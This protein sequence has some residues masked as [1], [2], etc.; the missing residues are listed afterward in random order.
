MPAM[1]RQDSNPHIANIAIALSGA[2]L[3]GVFTLMF[4]PLAPH[5]AG[6]SHAFASDFFSIAT[7]MAIA[8][9]VAR[10]LV[11]K[12]RSDHQ[13]QMERDLLEAF[14]EHIPDNVFFKDRESKFIRISRAMADYIG[15]AEPSQAIDKSDS[16]IFSSE[17]AGIAYADEQEIMRTGRPLVGIEEKETWPDGRESWALTTKVPLLNRTGQIIGTMGIARNIT[18]RKHA[19][20]RLRHMALHD[21]LTGLPNRALLEDG[22]GRAIAMAH[23]NHKC[24]AVLMLDLDRFKNIND[25][26][27]HHAGDLVLQAVAS[28]LKNGLRE[29]DI[30][31]R[32]GGDEFVIVLPSANG[33]EDVE[34]VAQKVI[35]RMVEPFQIDGTNLRVGVSIGICEYPADGEN[36]ESLLQCADAALYEVKKEG[37]GLYRFFT[38]D[39]IVA[40]VHRQNLENDL[41]Q[42]WEQ[43]Q[44]VLHYQP[45]VST[46]A[47]RMIGVEALMRWH[48]PE[49]GLIPPNR[50]IPQLEELGLMV[51][52]GA[53]ALATACRQNAAWQQEGLPPIRVAVN[54]S[55]QQFYRGDIVGVV[56]KTLRETGLDPKW[57]EL[58]LTESLTLDDSETTIKIMQELKRLGVSLSLDDFGTGWSSLSYLRRFPLD[59]LKIDRSFVREIGTEPASEAIVRGIITLGQNLGLS[60]VGEGV[61][62]SEQLD[63]LQ[64]LRCAETQGYLYSAAMPAEDCTALLRAETFNF[65][66]TRRAL[67]KAS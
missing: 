29:S 16:D 9:L 57:L 39:L 54:V 49:R 3:G 11:L 63:Y 20:A 17:H 19:E 31:A 35:E 33:K 50:F 27:G 62:T 25:S 67:E 28:R 6:G 4:M 64:K 30:V 8:V 52:V 21:T 51:N 36:S 60:C 2:M 44:F 13:H 42:A 40:T 1:K 43:G 56:E 15:L 23:R 5:G 59:R 22:I 10:L 41:H 7:I 18:D 24:V 58:E 32:L 45:L 47:G 46:D 34:R 66:N 53:W 37:R 55:A 26:L 12:S 38:R 61:E 14:L 65:K 48:H